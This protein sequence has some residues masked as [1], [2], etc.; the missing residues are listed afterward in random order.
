MDSAARAIC[1][2]RAGCTGASP[3]AV[4]R[5]DRDAL[6]RCAAELDAAVDLDPDVDRFCTRSDWI[7]SFHDAFHPQSEI[8]AARDGGA[9]VALASRR[10]LLEPLE[11]M[12]GFASPLVG[13]AAGE[14]LLEL[15]RARPGPEPLYLSGLAPAAPRTRELLR[16]LRTDFALGLASTTVR[17]VARLGGDGFLAR[18]TARF[19][20]NARAAMRRIRDAGV[21]FEHLAPRGAGAGAAAHARTLAVEG[22]SWKAATG[23]GVDRGP[24]CEF[25]RR[26][27][28]RLAARDA[29]RV[30]FARCGGEDV[31][32]LVGG[33]A[34]GLFRGL[35]FSFDERLRA[36]GVGN[37][38]QL[39]AIEALTQEGVA[40]YDLGGQSEYKAR[41]GELQVATVGVLARPRAQRA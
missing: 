27:L 9:F 2:S 34:G 22:H 24:M 19:R 3:S 35:Q 33:L 11:A 41:W 5:L 36:L 26:M 1:A 15:L 10:G 12:W 38:L 16:A 7:L 13:L 30:V 8:V 32:Y 29:L 6:E 40:L 4:R 18:R 39:E 28:P 21:A 20:R 25:Y 31:G 17:F 37:A 14:L 23:N